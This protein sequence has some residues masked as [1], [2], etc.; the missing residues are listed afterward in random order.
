MINVHIKGSGTKEETAAQ[1]LA[2]LAASHSPSLQTAPNI[3]LEIFPSRKCF[4]HKAEDIDLIVFYYDFR[5]N[6]HV[7]ASSGAELKSF[8]VTIEVK[9]HRAED[10]KFEGGN[11]SVL[12]QGQ[13]HD[14]T[15]QSDAQK[16]A[17]RQY[18]ESNLKGLKAPFVYNIIWLTGCPSAHLPTYESNILGSD[19]TWQD[20]LNKIA[21]LEKLYNSVNS[22]RNDIQFRDSVAVFSKSLQASRIDRKRMEAITRSV[23]DQESQ[24]YARKIGDQLL[25]FRGRGGTG[26]TVR[27]LRIAYQLYQE[28]ASRV[29]LLTYNSALAV[30]IKRLL[31]LLG[32]R[33]AVGEA[34]VTIRT[35]HSFM[36]E[37]LLELG[38]CDKSDFRNFFEKYT[39]YK[40]L[41]LEMIRKQAFT[42]ED[43]VAIKKNASR[44]L[45]WDHIFIDESQ[46]WPEDERDLLYYLYG[47]KNVIAADG[48]DQLVRSTKLIDWREDPVVKGNSQLVPLRR[49]LRLKST[50]CQAVAELANIIDYPFWDLVPEEGTYGGHVI[51][52]EGNILSPAF[53]KTLHAITV[54][55]GNEPIDVLFCVPPAWVVREGDRSYS[56]VSRWCNQNG[57]EVW[58]GVDNEE[59]HEIPTSSSQ[60]R[61]VQYDSC[62]GLEGWSVVACAIDEFYQYKVNTAEF[63]E[64]ATQDMYFDKDKSAQEFAKRWLMIPMTRAI[65][66]LIINLSDADTF[67]GKALKELHKNHPETVEWRKL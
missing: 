31:H 55:D 26:K 11:C 54:K 1:A 30:D 32:I 43:V 51:V 38:I 25:I 6:G 10:I 36:R 37:W 49:S 15:A 45:A 21:S 16:H 41:A 8:G 52:V 57:Y 20:L 65:D 22:F 24:K 53:A 46:D 59:R 58:D 29:I 28:N 23:L 5:Q 40:L 33:N 56:R 64:A 63:S 14:V 61:V 66:T 27:L 7:A 42:P 67:V 18:L 34:A 19:A 12:Y 2:N 44:S 50:L 17:L 62:R 13:W 3:I 35:I 48:V 47:Y 4:G 9:S 60:F 39:E